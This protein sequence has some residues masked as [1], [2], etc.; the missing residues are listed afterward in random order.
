MC[1]KNS[2]AET[3]EERPK[4]R[5][6]LHL[7]LLLLGLGPRRPGAA[8]DKQLRLAAVLGLEAAHAQPLVQVQHLERALHL[9]PARLQADLRP[10]ADQAP[11]SGER[12]SSSPPHLR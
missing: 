6:V 7:G 3:T 8:E 12:T 11:P 10:A 5:A 9:P 4:G 2:A 1:T